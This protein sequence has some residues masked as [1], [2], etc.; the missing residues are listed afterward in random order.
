MYIFLLKL[1]AEKFYDMVN[2]KIKANYL[3]VSTIPNY[4]T[5]VRPVKYA[6]VVAG[7]H[8]FRTL[9]KQV[10]YCVGCKDYTLGDVPGKYQL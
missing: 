1:C 7:F 8:E 10:A 3:V 5:K 2:P 4:Y 6:E 9:L